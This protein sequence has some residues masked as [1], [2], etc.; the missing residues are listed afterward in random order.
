[1]KTLFTLLLII[2]TLSLTPSAYSMIVINEFLAD[3]TAG[4]GGDANRDGI[5]HSYDDEF[6]ELLN[7]ESNAVDL[8]LWT[9]SDNTAI[10]HKFTTG[11]SIAQNERLVIF[12]GGDLSRFPFEAVTASSGSLHLTN[13]GDKIVLKNTMYEIMD[14]VIFGNEADRD[15]SLTRFPEGT[16]SFRLHSE[17]SSKKFLFSPGTNREGKD[18]DTGSTPA[19]P[20]PSTDILLFLGWIA[21][22]KIHFLTIFSKQRL[23]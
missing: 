6:I 9:I 16:G 22:L 13:S 10:R 23:N 21:F 17:V 4:T 12:G 14:S 18:K 15:Q 5:R 20:E 8:S 11:T 2:F 3:P 1:M 19:V 7:V